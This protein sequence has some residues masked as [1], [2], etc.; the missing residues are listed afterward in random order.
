M[1]GLLGNVVGAEKT[2]D[3]SVIWAPDIHVRH[4]PLAAK[5]QAIKAILALGGGSPQCR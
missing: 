5:G 3:L 1:K 4:P 2:G